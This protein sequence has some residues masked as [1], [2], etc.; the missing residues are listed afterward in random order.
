MAYSNNTSGQNHNYSTL[1]LS[2]VD[3]LEQSIHNVLQ[4][5]QHSDSEDKVKL[6]QFVMHQIAP[7]FDFHYMARWVAGRRFHQ[8]NELQQEQF[9]A[10]F[11]EIF[12]RKFITKMTRNKKSLP[13]VS[14]FISNKQNQ[15][16]A[17]ASVLLNYNGDSNSQPQRIKVDFRF[18]NT[19]NGWKVVDIKAN[20]LSALMYFRGYFNRLMR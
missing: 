8:M 19:A 20:G 5:L 11:A 18:L 1:Q 6:K 17:H 14:R 15:N 3:L 10:K 13:S 2:P 7:N 4:F 16:E 12:I 9:S